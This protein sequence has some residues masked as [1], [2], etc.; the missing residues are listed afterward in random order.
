[1]T[2]AGSEFQTDGAAHRSTFTHRHLLLFNH[3]V[4]THL[5]ALGVGK[6][7]RHKHYSKCAARAKNC[8]RCNFCERNTQKLQRGSI[9]E[10]WAPLESVVPLNHCDLQLT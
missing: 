9:L 3:N 8:A 5:P 6:L 1:M 7:F 2:D 10:P 4:D